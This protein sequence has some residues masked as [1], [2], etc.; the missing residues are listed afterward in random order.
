MEMEITFSL[1][2]A[3]LVLRF[4][5]LGSYCAEKWEGRHAFH[6]I[7]WELGGA[8]RQAHKWM[9]QSARRKISGYHRHLRVL[10]ANWE[11]ELHFL[12]G[13]LFISSVQVAFVSRSLVFP[14]FLPSVRP[15]ISPF[16]YLIPVSNKIKVEVERCMKT[17]SC[18]PRACNWKEST[19]C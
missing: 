14:H 4:C 6:F 18:L 10:L 5:A 17:G 3:M 19:G 1:W 2:N 15:Q 8:E 7:L 9:L 11:S 12:L 13:L 16:I